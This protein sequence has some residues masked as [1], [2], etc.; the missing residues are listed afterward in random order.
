MDVVKAAL[1]SNRML[2]TQDKSA[3]LVEKEE[4]IMAPAF[5]KL[6]PIFA[7]F[8]TLRSFMPSPQNP[9]I[10]YFLELC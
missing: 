6:M 10:I 9:T 4:A 1:P 8:K 3:D 7:A 5:L 2:V